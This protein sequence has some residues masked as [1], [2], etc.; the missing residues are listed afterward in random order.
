MTL[1][2]PWSF[3]PVCSEHWDALCLCLRELLD[4]S[5]TRKQEIMCGAELK[6]SGSPL[7]QHRLP[8]GCPSL[9]CL[10]KPDYPAVLTGPL[11]CDFKVSLPSLTC[12]SLSPLSGV[13]ASCQCPVTQPAP[14]LCKQSLFLNK[15]LSAVP[16]LEGKLRVI[17]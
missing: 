17:T 11:G 3:C 4:P 13:Q 15:A 10:V 8:V 7:L 9:E 6:V 1:S 5:V 16:P 14:C 2:L 12:L